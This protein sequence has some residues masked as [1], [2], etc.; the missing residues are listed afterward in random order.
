MEIRRKVFSTV[1]NQ[2]EQD[3]KSGPSIGALAATTGLTAG[4]GA[5]EYANNRGLNNRVNDLIAKQQTAN[6][7]AINKLTA[8]FNQKSSNLLGKD[9]EKATSAFNSQKASLLK[10]SESRIG[11]LN[12]SKITARNKAI[13]RTGLVGVGLTALPFLMGRKKDNQQ[14]PQ[15]SPQQ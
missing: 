2:Q 8:D 12:A 5:F 11:K 7:N 15:N 14:P 1:P 3:K 6:T 10:T 13:A 9:I 4:Y